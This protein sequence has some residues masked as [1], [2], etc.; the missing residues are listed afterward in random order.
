M[1]ARPA[2]VP[3]LRL[4]LPGSCAYAP[5]DAAVDTAGRITLRSCPPPTAIYSDRI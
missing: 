2:A 1:A 3:T 5:N 4:T